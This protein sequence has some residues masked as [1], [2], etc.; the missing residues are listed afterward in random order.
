MARTLDSKRRGPARGEA[1]SVVVFLHGYGADG[2]DLLGLSDPLAEH[3]PGTAFH[4][5]DAPEQSVVNPMGF[6][7]FPIPWLDGSDPTAADE[8]MDRAASDLNAYLDSVLA[9]EGLSADRMVV[10]G[11]SQGTMMALHVALRRT[12]EVAG[13]VGFSGRLLRPETLE[14]EIAVRPP[15]LLIHG[16]QDEV[17]PPASL[18]AAAEALQAAGVDVF[19]HVSKGVAHGIAPDGLSVALAFMRERLGLET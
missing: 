2:A 15:V 4:A 19:A 1:G 14:D 16:D 3:M 6:Q 17:V 18:P 12:A 5:P 9:E 8:A 13:I 7:W 11:F 10:V